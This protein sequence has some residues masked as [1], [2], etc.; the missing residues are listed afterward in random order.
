M[1]IKD[2]KLQKIKAFDFDN[3]L[4][5]NNNLFGLP[6]AEEES[7]IILL[8]I[9]W[10]VTTSYKDGTHAAPPAIK[11]AA[12]QIELFDKDFENSWQAGFFMADV[13]K[14]L[15]QKNNEARAL[16]LQHI[17]TLSTQK[18]TVDHNALKAI[19]KA[20][21][22]MNLYVEKRAS[23]ILAKDKIAAVLGGEHSTPLGLLKALSRHHQSFSI[24]HIDAH[25]DLRKAYM[26][27]EF[28]HASIMYNALKIPAVK[29][30]TQV[31]VRDYGKQEYD[32]IQQNPQRL[33]CFFDADIKEDLQ[34]KR[35]WPAIVT[36]ILNTLHQK[37]YVSFDIDGLTPDLCP[38]T[39][40]PVPGGLSF[41][42]ATDLISRLASSGKTI[43]GFDLCETGVSQN[44]WDENIAAR[45]LYKLCCATAATQR[46]L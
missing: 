46:A 1:M 5:E 28:S 17:R 32:M 30:I 8:P 12:T 18:Q 14:E 4:P 16:A 25:A 20:C 40:T 31:A 26:G 43:I 42:E 35:N 27:F 3:V 41:Y 37:V 13:S 24:L 9:P 36:D 45:I 21:K 19:N 39:G 29:N 2:S 23:E 15:L 38:H 33:Q 34:H 11:R 7:D 22:D 10:D 44:E 6:F